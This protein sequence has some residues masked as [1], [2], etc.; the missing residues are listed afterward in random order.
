M[1]EEKPPRIDASDVTF[2]ELSED[3][4]VEVFMKDGYTDYKKRSMRYKTL[5]RDSIFATAPATMFVAFLGETPVGVIGYGKYKNLLLDAG[6]HVRKEYRGRGLT[7]IL[8]DK[9]IEEKG[10]KTYLVNISEPNIIS[11]YRDRGFVD[12][13]RTDLPEEILDELDMAGDLEQVQ[14]YMQHL[15]ERWMGILKFSAA[16]RP[17]QIKKPEEVELELDKDALAESCCQQAKL[18]FAEG[19]TKIND[20]MLEK[21]AG[22]PDFNARE[23]NQL[24]DKVINA[25]DTISCDDLRRLLR[26]VLRFPHLQLIH[27]LTRDILKDWEECESGN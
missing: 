6:V 22:K 13:D 12:I 4:A 19:F 5:P 24:Y 8:V 16:M 17:S 11:T 1:V 27:S 21:Y 15:P 14:K 10:N 7:G 26:E 18:A 9:I 3:K 23:L 20:E 2:R 25:L